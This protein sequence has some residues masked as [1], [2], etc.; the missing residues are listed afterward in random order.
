[1]QIV[2]ISYRILGHME[3]DLDF[4]PMDGISMLKK[5]EYAGRISHRSEERITDDSYDKFLRSVVLN[6]GDWSITEHA[7]VT[8]EVEADR[9]ITHE[10]VRHRIAS[11]T[12]ESTR[13][14]NYDKQEMR[15]IEP[16]FK[17][18]RSKALW[19]MRVQQLE[20]TY[21]E[22]LE[23][24]ESPQLAR[25]VLPNSLASKL[26]MTFN[27]RS[28]RWFFIMRCSKETHPQMKELTIPLLA[29]FKRLIPILFE[30]IEP[31]MKQSEAMRL[32]G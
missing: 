22:L 7:S 23:N 30:D 15:F 27:L 4:L 19:L 9:G 10:I 6:H 14:V 29:D 20:L 13:F 17:D 1:M 16:P 11:Y 25:S 28:W 26:V 8:V 12:Q 5:I 3:H 18:A 31:N 24:G 21:L 32:L 2:P